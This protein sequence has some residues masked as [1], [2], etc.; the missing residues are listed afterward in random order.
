L[1]HASRGSCGRGEAQGCVRPNFQVDGRVVEPFISQPR[2]KIDARNPAL[3]HTIRGVGYTLR[4]G[5]TRS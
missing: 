5:G 2:R 1:P 4:L 3:I